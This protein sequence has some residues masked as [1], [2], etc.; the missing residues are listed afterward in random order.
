[1][2]VIKGHTR[3]LDYSLFTLPTQSAHAASVFGASNRNACTPRRHTKSMKS[4][5]K[6]VKNV[7][8]RLYV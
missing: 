4:E 3:S 1:M 6:V 5:M 8:M 7:R 2:G